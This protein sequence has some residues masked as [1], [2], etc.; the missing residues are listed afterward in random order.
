MNKVIETKNLTKVYQMGEVEV[1]AIEDVSI[2]IEEG[3]FV[4]IMGP[5]GSGKSTLMHLLGLLDK[6]TQGK[7]FIDGRNTSNLS[8]NDMADFRLGRIG[9]VFQFYSLLKG[10][11]SLE[12]IVLPQ[13]L[14]DVSEDK[15]Q[16]KAEKALEKVNMADRINHSPNELSGGQ[17]Q[18]V[19]VARALASD[20]DI[21]FADESTSQLDTESSEEI[22][23]LYRNLA[24]QGQTVVT[25]NHEKELGQEAD[26]VIWLVDG[27]IESR[28]HSFD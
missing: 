14:N 16:E 12:Q 28:N 9:F 10:F 8:D 22:M 27:N 5:S 21:L 20:P 19:A 1:K 7:I 17:R 11:D 25:V 4:S 6:P 26:R 24:N 13:I 2:E 3:E 23:Q 18:R 15:A